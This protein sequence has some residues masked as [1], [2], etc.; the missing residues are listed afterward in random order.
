MEAP[1]KFLQ[2]GLDFSSPQPYQILL[3]HSANHFKIIHQLGFIEPKSNSITER[4]WRK[5]N[6]LNQ[7]TLKRPHSW[8]TRKLIWPDFTGASK[9][10]FEWWNLRV[11]RYVRCLNSN[12]VN[13][14]LFFFNN[15]EYRKIFQ[16]YAKL[17]SVCDSR[18]FTTFFHAWVLKIENFIKGKKIILVLTQKMGEFNWVCFSRAK[19]KWKTRSVTSLNNPTLFNEF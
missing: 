4:K 1:N 6:N 17:C 7:K 5:N 13:F 10:L 3:D 18:N 15:Y 14:F 19:K 8:K 11:F 9:L 12:I 2:K 16:I